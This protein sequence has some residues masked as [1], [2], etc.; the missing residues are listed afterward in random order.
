MIRNRLNSVLRGATSTAAF[1]TGLIFVATN[2]GATPAVFFNDDLVAG[3]Q[4]FVDTAAAAD[5]AYNA[6]NPGA[7]QDSVIFR[8]DLT[9]S[10]GNQ[11]SV[12]DPVSAITVYVRTAL[13]GSPANNSTTGDEGEIGRASGRERVYQYV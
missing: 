6:A 8:L 4:T 9:N 11:F 1:A 12:T 5:A 2:A 7:T 10:T 3:E 13:A